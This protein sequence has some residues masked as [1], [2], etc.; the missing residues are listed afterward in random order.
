MY[1]DYIVKLQKNDISPN[2]PLPSVSDP[3]VM[4]NTL[5]LATN[6]NIQQQLGKCIKRVIEPYG[7]HNKNLQHTIYQVSDLTTIL[8]KLPD[9]SSSDNDC[10]CVSE[11]DFLER[12]NKKYHGLQ[13]IR[14]ITITDDQEADVYVTDISPSVESC[15]TRLN[16]LNILKTWSGRHMMDKFP[17]NQ[18]NPWRYMSSNESL[19]SIEKDTLTLHYSKYGK[20]IRVK[21]DNIDLP[22]DLEHKHS[23]K[24]GSVIR[25]EVCRYDHD[26]EELF[27][28]RY[29]FLHRHVIE[30]R[31]TSFFLKKFHD[32]EK[33]L[34]LARKSLENNLQI[35]KKL[36]KK[37]EKKKN[38]LKTCQNELE[39]HLKQ[40]ESNSQR[41]RKNRYRVVNG[42]LKDVLCD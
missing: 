39:S 9:T 29:G 26:W 16:L 38:I 6:F 15:F 31:E 24:D 23:L 2:K 35:S 3:G 8:K 28:C 30:K 34:E 27:T 4:E 37:F 20:V 40:F 19:F 36:S 7:P 21:I 42:E 22:Y 10:G 12:C 13:D 14:Y 32:S 33:E 1:G 41:V 18:C 25:V 5:Q 17:N 11:E